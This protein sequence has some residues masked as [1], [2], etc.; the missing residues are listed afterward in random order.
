ML[1]D[2]NGHDRWHPA[3]ERSE[4]EFGE[5]ADK[6]GCVRHFRLRDGA[7]LREQLLSLSDRDMS[8]RYF[9]VEAPVP[10]RNYVAEMRLCAVTSDG[11]TVCEWR[12][13]F[14]PPARRARGADR[15]SCARRSS[16]PASRR[17][18]ARCWAKLSA[19]APGARRGRAKPRG[20]PGGAGGHHYALGRPRGDG[21]ADRSRSQSPRAGEARI[22][23]TAIGVN[24]IDVYCRRGSFTLVPPGGTLGH[25]GGGRG[26]GDRPRRHV[27]EA[28]ATASPTPARRPAPTRACATCPRD[29]L[30]PPAGRPQR[31]EG[32]GADA[33]GHDGELS[34]STTCMR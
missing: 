11:S 29:M 1:R 13:E 21:T 25:G 22:R 14:D 10:L 30:V 12:A 8:F 26:R 24:F 19:D 5:P 20:R 15:A 4:I 28:R 33:E 7:V 32:C 23:Q 2:F 3:V 17:F 9:I 34:C 18:A 31:C 16:T 27:R 6:I